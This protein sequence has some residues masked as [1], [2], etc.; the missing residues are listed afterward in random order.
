MKSIKIYD[1]ECLVNFFSYMDIDE[2]GETYKT[3]VLSEETN[4]LNQM[5][6][7]L[8]NEAKGMVGFNNLGYDYYLLEFIFANLKNWETMKFTNA[9]ILAL[10]Y[11]KSQEVISGKKYHQG[12]YI[13]PQLDLFKIWHF[14][15]KAKRQSLKG[16]QFHMKLPNVQDMPYEHFERVNPSQQLLILEYNKNDVWA[17]YQFWLVSAEKI[18]IRRDLTK[19]YGLDFM[20][21]SDSSMGEKLVLYLYCIKTNQPVEKVEKLRSYRHSIKFSNIIFPYVNFKTYTFQRLLEEI[22]MI[23][24]NSKDAQDLKLKGIYEKEVIFGNIWFKYGMGG[25]HGSVGWKIFKSNQQKVIMDADVSSL[26]PELGIKNNLYPKHL[27]PVFVQVYKEDIVD[28]RLLAK[29]E[30]RKSEAEG[31]KL[32]ANSVYGKS[33]SKY[34]FMY[35]PVYTLKTTINGQLLLTM[36]AE[37]LSLSIPNLEMIQINTDGLTVRID[38]KDL[39]TYNAVC[40]QW[41]EATKLNLEYVEYE[42]MIIKDVNNYIAIKK[43]CDRTTRVKG[44]PLSYDNVKYKG[45]T[46][47]IVKDYHKNTSFQVIPYVLSEFFVAGKD[48]KETLMSITD[49]YMFFGRLRFRK[50]S[51]GTL[52]S[53]EDGELVEEEQQKTMRYYISNTGGSLIKHFTEKNKSQALEKGYKITPANRVTSSDIKDYDIDYIYYLSECMAV[54]KSFYSDQ[55]TLF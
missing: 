9:Q 1:L 53:I 45:D 36:L 46:F 32:A 52:L 17:T 13:V 35:D 24:V 33:N 2:K 5:C 6:H 30:G 54:Q 25:I 26:Y 22:K 44:D 55:T 37:A 42:E 14:D 8:I 39:D 34:S 48:I 27:G 50:D 51:K 16:L 18:K 28:P 47:E 15:N 38:R 10:I 12:P 11:E 3:F 41:C 21:L 23:Q 49:P 4:E 7:Y 29:A 31:G 40:N 43:G 20:N 19:K